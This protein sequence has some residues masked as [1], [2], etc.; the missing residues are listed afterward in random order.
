MGPIGCSETSVLNYY[1]AR[2]IPEEPRSHLLHVEV[3]RAYGKCLATA[4]TQS[5]APMLYVNV[6]WSPCTGYKYLTECTF[7]G[8]TQNT[9]IF[10]R[11]CVTTY[12]FII[13]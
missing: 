10:K 4:V 12:R 9:H 1:S 6:I 7:M 13:L 5:N 3:K 2:N 11:S 8:G